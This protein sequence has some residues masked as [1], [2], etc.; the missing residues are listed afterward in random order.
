MLDGA[1]VV[2]DVSAAGTA[3]RLYNYY[4]GSYRLHSMREGSD[5]YLY[6]TEEGAR[7]LAHHQ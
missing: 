6:L 4:P 5:G 2:A 1:T 7:D 3:E